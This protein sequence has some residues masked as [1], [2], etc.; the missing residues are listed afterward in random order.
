[1][2]VLGN[3]CIILLCIFLPFI[4]VIVIGLQRKWGSG[5]LLG[6][7][8]LAFF[9]TLLGWIPGMIFAFVVYAGHI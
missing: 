4:A 5:K 3:I 7:G 8:I 6:M 9:L 1:M 2:S